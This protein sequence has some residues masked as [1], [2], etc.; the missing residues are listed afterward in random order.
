[1]SADDLGDLAYLRGIEA[2]LTEAQLEAFH[3]LLFAPE[4]RGDAGIRGAAD[5]AVRELRRRVG[6]S[7][8]KG[9]V[10]DSWRATG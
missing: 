7:I 3:A 6:E 1:M 2:T 4:Y 9:V 10:K 8:A 5:K